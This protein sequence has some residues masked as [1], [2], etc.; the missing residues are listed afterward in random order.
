MEQFLAVKTK[1]ESLCESEASG[2]LTDSQKNE[3][4]IANLIAEIDRV[5]NLDSAAVKEC[6]ATVDGYLKMT[7]ILV[8]EKPESAHVMAR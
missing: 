3:L 6:L 4:V 2:D 8:K 5:E 7:Q 1:L